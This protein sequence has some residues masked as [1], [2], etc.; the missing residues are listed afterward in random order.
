MLA[1]VSFIDSSSN[2][3]F[4]QA[5]QR[6]RTDPSQS[7]PTSWETSAQLFSQDDSAT[8][9]SWTTGLGSQFSGETA[10]AILGAQEATTA[11][12]TSGENDTE[13]GAAASTSESETTFSFDPLDT[14]Q[15]GKVSYLEWL[16]GQKTTTNT[17]A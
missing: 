16:E 13:A 6:A 4:L 10:S 11:E 7:K 3:L 9:S 15:D 12:A 5:S 14:N 2:D 1:P 8:V 17:A